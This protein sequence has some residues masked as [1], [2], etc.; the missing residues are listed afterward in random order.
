VFAR[1]SLPEDLAALRAATVPDAVVLNAE[2]DFGTLPPAVAEELGLP[3]DAL[4][5]V[6]YPEAWLP[7]D[8]PE[9]LRRYAGP[10]F[11]VGLPGDGTVVWTRRTDPPA[12]ILERRAETTPDE[13]L[14][15]LIAE[16]FV[17]LSVAGPSGPVAPDLLAFLG[18]RYPDLDRAVPL[19]PAAVYQIARALYDARLGLE[20]RDAFAGWA[21]ER[22]RLFAAWQD[23]GERIEGRLPGLPREVARGETEF[24]AATE[25]AC[26]AIKHGLDLP[27]PFAALNT[28]AYREYGADYAVEWAATTFERLEG[29]GDARDDGTD[30]D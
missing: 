2:T 18:G 9:P 29:T 24:A 10:E 1:R 12:V 20:T 13:F 26:A 11:T 28:A 16:A 23:A 27:A 14:D 7:A 30:P 3:V 8:A 15:F 4:D 17:A 25:Y 5:P 6:S 19:G 21:G 22:D